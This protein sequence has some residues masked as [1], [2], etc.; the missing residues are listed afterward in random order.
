MFIK[1]NEEIKMKNKF[2]VHVFLDD[3]MEVEVLTFKTQGI[4]QNIIP[5]VELQ[6]KHWNSIVIVDLL[7]IADSTIFVK[8][9][10]FV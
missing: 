10:M 3:N 1:I 8:S 2:I 7:D 4:I 5:Q 6:C 9:E